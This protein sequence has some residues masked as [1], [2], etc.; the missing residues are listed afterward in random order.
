MYNNNNNNDNNY[1]NNYNNNFPFPHQDYTS[2]LMPSIPQKSRNGVYEIENKDQYE[3]VVDLSRYRLALWFLFGSVSTFFCFTHHMGFFYRHL[4]KA[5]PDKLIVVK[6]FASYCRA[7][8]G[9]EPKFLRI[10]DD[11]QLVGLPIVWAEYQA[12]TSNKDFFQKLGV[13]TLPTIQFYD[14]DRGLIENF[15]CGPAK[16]S[17]LKKKMARFLN[18]RV[19]PT[20]RQ[21]KISTVLD[22]SINQ[23]QPQQQ[24]QQQQQQQPT[25]AQEQQLQTQ[26][27]QQRPRNERE[28]VI[29]NEL[30]RDEHIQYLRNGMPFFQDLSDEEFDTLLSKARLQTYNPGDVIMRQGTPPTTFFVI[31]RGIAE[32][33]IKSKFEDPIRTPPYYLGA[34]VNE[35]KKFDYFG[36]RALTT[37]EPYAASVRVLEKV[38]VFAFDVK[39]IPESSILSKKRRATREMVE[40]LSKRYELPEDYTPAIQQQEQQQQ[41]RTPYPVT[42]RDECVLELLVRFKQIRQAAKCFEYVMKSEPTWGDEGEIARRSMLANK[43]SKSQK[44]EFLEVF[45]MVDIH[46][47]GRISLLEMRKFMESARAS[48]STDE[49]MEMMARANPSFHYVNSFE[50]SRDEFMGVMAEAEF[51]NLFT[52]T[53]QDLDQENTGYVRAGDL[54][55]VLGGVRDLIS[56]DRTSIIDVEDKDMLVDYEQFSKMLLGAAL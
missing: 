40:L 10:K 37:G 48:K 36:E 52:E 55:D 14:G 20:T 4:V 13:L 38:R 32:M 12:Q 35:L 3:Y 5:H 25:N 2:S 17:L 8:K 33:S 50:I 23:Q 11:P 22:G 18:Q 34:V 54:D 9:L 41:Q 56:N 53:F 15:P 21:L 6:F 1:G 26:L 19:D 43:L 45:S 27:Q 7:C 28:I 49:L 16:T 47:T 46:S 42:E 29:D 24:Q 51:Y 31:K 30:I 44:E 39:D